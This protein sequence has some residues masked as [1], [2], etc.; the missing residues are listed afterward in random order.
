MHVHIDIHF[1]YDGRV[2]VSCFN[3]FSG[4]PPGELILIRYG[5]YSGASAL[6]G[7][8][9]ILNLELN[10]AR[11][12]RMKQNDKNKSYL[13]FYETETSPLV[14]SLMAH[15]NVPHLFCFVVILL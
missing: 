6:Y 8:D 11:T 12:I 9:I 10:N 2:H 4:N 5:A 14:V 15:Y 13:I 7:V 3:A 1:Y